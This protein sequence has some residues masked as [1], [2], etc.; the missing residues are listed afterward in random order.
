MYSDEK[1]DEPVISDDD[2]NA[3]CQSLVGD[4]QAKD[5]MSYI[6]CLSWFSMFALYDA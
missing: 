4:T 5:C 2:H 1:S 6:L 3:D